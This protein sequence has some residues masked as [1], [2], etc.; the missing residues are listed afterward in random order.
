MVLE[1]PVSFS[2]SRQEYATQ[3]A[4]YLVCTGDLMPLWEGESI[5]FVDATY[6]S[7]IV[8]ALA[9]YEADKG[10]TFCLGVRSRVLRSRASDEST[11][12]R[13]EVVPSQTQRPQRARRTPP[14]PEDVVRTPRVPSTKSRNQKPQTKP[15]KSEKPQKSQKPQKTPAALPP[16]QK[17]DEQSTQFAQMTAQVCCFLVSTH[18]ITYKTFFFWF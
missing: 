17:Q 15:Q 16:P 12:S 2:G 18:K 8:R 4:I 10:S 14:V 1:S 7:Q 9:A 6:T 11:H 13:P 3:A 5:R